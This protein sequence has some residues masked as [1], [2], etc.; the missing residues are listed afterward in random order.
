MKRITFDDGSTLFL[1]D[2]AIETVRQYKAEV[3]FWNE[4]GGIILGSQSE[5]APVFVARELTLPAKEDDCGPIHYM[6]DKDAA[7]KLIKKAWKKSGG[8]VNYLGEWHTHNESKP[9]P[10]YVDENLMRQ[11][12]EN[13]SCLFDRA[14]MI[15]L[16]NRG[17][18]FVGVI[19]PK[20]REV[21][22]DSCYVDLY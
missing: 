20:E 21:F 5:D 9:H 22:L 7:N 17:K 15:I 10:S 14:F 18:A 16:G 12:A 3:G 11:I 8:T 1:A 2:E 4:S 6:R 19:D 13:E